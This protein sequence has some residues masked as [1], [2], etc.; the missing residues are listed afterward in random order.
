MKVKVVN[1]FRDKKA[2]KEIVKLGTELEVSKE[3]YEEIK[4]YVE[5]INSTKKEKFKRV[6]D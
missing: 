1:V 6:E 4:E 5:I 3:R 2:P